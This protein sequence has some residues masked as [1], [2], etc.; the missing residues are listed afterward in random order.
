MRP[1]TQAGVA[2]SLPFCGWCGVPASALPPG[3]SWDSA[4]QVWV[5]RPHTGEGEAEEEEGAAQE[6][7]L[8]VSNE[9][10]VR[11]TDVAYAP[12]ASTPPPKGDAA[13]SQAATDE[14]DGGTL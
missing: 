1:A 8:D 6:L 10:V 3:T 12:V 5:W 13:A 9:S 14:C 7:F 11:V 4:E 2:L